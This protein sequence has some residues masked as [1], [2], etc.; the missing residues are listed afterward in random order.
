MPPVVANCGCGSRYLE[1][2]STSNGSSMRFT[3]MFHAVQC[4]GI[5]NRGLIIASIA[6][7]LKI[8]RYL[9]FETFLFIKHGRVAVINSVH[10]VRLI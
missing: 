4:Q 5:T 1:L 6:K 9:L 2:F 10:K 8:T 7:I 3:Q